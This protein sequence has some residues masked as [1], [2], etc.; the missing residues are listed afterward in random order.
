MKKM[1]KS[2]LPP[3]AETVPEES[4]VNQVSGWTFKKVM[5]V[6]ALLGAVSAAAWSWHTANAQTEREVR[7]CMGLDGDEGK[8]VSTPLCSKWTDQ[9]VRQLD[10]CVADRF[11]GKGW[12]LGRSVFHVLADETLTRRQLQDVMGDECVPD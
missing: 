10:G 4:E 6:I 9:Q 3:Q 2:E 7:A 12:S 5:S 1:G 8:R 11:Y